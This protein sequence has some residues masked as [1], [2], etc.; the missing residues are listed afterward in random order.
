MKIIKRDGRIE[1]PNYIK[2]SNAIQKATNGS[3]E[4]DEYKLTCL[5]HECLDGIKE[6]YGYDSTILVEDIHDEVIDFLKKNKLYQL[7]INYADYRNIRDKSRMKKT[8][9][10]KV[11]DLIGQANIS[12]DNGNVG[13]NFSAKLLR[14]ASESNKYNN[15]AKMPKEISRLH[16]VGDLYYHDLDSFNLTTNCLH[17]PLKKLLTRGFNTGYGDINPPKRIESGAALACIILQ[18]SQNQWFL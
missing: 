6:K 8:E 5:A 9:L 4:Y 3:K 11:I 18:S 7:A 13:S 15:L 14:I 1:E 17:I 16:E 10:M 12:S 2:I